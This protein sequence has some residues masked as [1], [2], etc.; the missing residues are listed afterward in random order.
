MASRLVLKRL[1]CTAPIALSIALLG[2]EA[3]AGDPA[4]CVQYAQNAVS[5]GQQSVAKGCNFNGPRW[6][7]GYQQHYDWCLAV[8]DESANF[9]TQAREAEL[10]KCTQGGEKM[11]PLQPG[12]LQPAQP[13][14]IPPGELQSTQQACTAYAQAAVAQNAKNLAEKCGLSGPAWNSNVDY[15]YQWCVSGK[16]LAHTAAQTKARDNH[17]AQCGMNKPL[18]GTF[19]I[20]WVTPKLY[21]SG[22]V[23]EIGINIE[24]TSANVWT[25]GDYGHPKYGSLW[26][27]V[28]ATNM[29]WENGLVKAKKSKP[30]MFSVRGIAG[31]TQAFLGQVIPAKVPAGTHNMTLQVKPAY[32]NMQLAGVRQKF[33]VESSAP[34]EPGKAG[35]WFD[36]PKIDVEVFIVTTGNVATSQSATTGDIEN[37]P[38][39]TVDVGEKGN[40][41]Y[42]DCN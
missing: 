37:A 26:A 11:V 24:F 17:L 39:T 12:T 27:E 29:V 2:G 16:N 6:Q 7:A 32:P 30:Y 13:V 31:G 25:I 23:D 1:V 21:P 18:D 40:V 15:H 14:P 35:C 33:K 28:T 19:K 20:K 38:L 36:Y 42:Y 9:E 4:K 10:A 41:I 34:F 22:I 8:P 5:Q 3:N